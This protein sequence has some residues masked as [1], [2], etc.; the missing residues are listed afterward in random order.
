MRVTLIHN[1]EA[2]EESLSSRQLLQ[3]LRNAGYEP[4]YQSVKQPGW[5]AALQRPA[6]LFV[7]AGGD[8]TIRKVAL[9]LQR[10]AVP[11][12]LLPLGTANNIATSLGIA[13]APDE[14]IAQWPRWRP[15]PF[16]PGLARGPWG[17]G[18]FMESA[19]L[20]LLSTAFEHPRTPDWKPRL[21]DV[22]QRWSGLLDK[23]QPIPIEIDVDGRDCSGSYLLAQAM[24]TKRAGPALQLAPAATMND[25]LHLALA[26]ANERAELQRY[27]SALSDHGP[28]APPRLRVERGRTLRMSWSAARFTIEDQ[29]WPDVNHPAPTH[30]V[31]VLLS[32]TDAGI[33]F[34]APRDGHSQS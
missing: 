11:I 26:T 1:P 21:A 15:R 27:F 32:T 9:G 16:R 13:G 24:N 7:A 28:A 20:G 34:L 18:I 4:D 12:A 5:E 3:L 6:Q 8:G 23:A 19:G 17:E 10:H 22:W 33:S 14:L 31:N 29:V 30:T 2:G 25:E